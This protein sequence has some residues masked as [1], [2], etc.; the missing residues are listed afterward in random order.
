[1]GSSSTGLRPGRLFLL[2][3]GIVFLLFLAVP[4]AV[5]LA[6]DPERLDLN[7]SARRSAPGQFARLADGYTHYEIGGPPDGRVVVLAAGATVPYYIWDPTFAA[8][9]AAGFRV[10][11]YDYYGRGFSDRPDIPF[12]QDLYVRQ[13]TQLLEF[14]HITQP[15]D[16]AGLSF[17]GSVITTIAD[18]H[19]S[20]VRSLVYMDPAFRT[21]LALSPLESMPRLWS[22][23]TAIMDERLWAKGQLDDF[24]Y[25]EKFPDWPDRYRVQMQYR[26]FRRSRLSDLAA[27][28]ERRSARGSAARRSRAAARSRR[29]GQAGSQRALRVQRAADAADAVR[30]PAGGRRCGPSAAVGEAR[31]RAAGNRGV[32][33][34]GQPM[35]R[36]RLALAAA[37]ALA[38][39]SLTYVASG[40]SRTSMPALAAAAELPARF[41]DQE[42]WKLMSDISEPNGNFRSDNLV[43]NEIRYQD[44]V[45]ALVQNIRPGGVYLGVGP[46]QNFTYIAAMRP[47]VAFILDLRRGNADLHLMYKALFELSAD[48]A[49]FVS[50]LFSRRR[51]DGLSATSTAAEIFS[52]FAQVGAERAVL[53]RDPGRHPQSARHRTP[54][55]AQRRRPDADRIDLQGLL[56]RRHED[57]VLARTA[58][59]AG[60][61]S[62][63]TPS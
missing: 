8:L 20:R 16:L 10:L 44:V 57:S 28:A 32:S 38:Y 13:F 33:A 46:E 47:R 17:G 35:T 51:P 2:Y 61:C 34:G 3:G 11:R 30:A 21:P 59:S 55:R 12:T 36:R 60:R 31:H 49:D 41:S 26:G 5:Y 25:P 63:P 14:L 6:F 52:A 56:P 39:V 4:T 50:R 29:L 40:F 7:D 23:V 27:N 58:V 18:R 45:A 37:V 54:L 19:P 15:V 53:E 48:R 42:Y 24:L 43:S 62:R 9:T 1:M 22:F